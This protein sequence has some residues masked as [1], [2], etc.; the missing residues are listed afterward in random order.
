MLKHWIEGSWWERGSL[1]KVS[2]L[3][4]ST[5]SI[6]T[7]WRK[8]EGL[9][10]LCSLLVTSPWLSREFCTASKSEA[11]LHRLKTP[12]SPWADKS[13]GEA[14]TAAPETTPGRQWTPVC[15][16]GKMAQQV[17][18]AGLLACPGNICGSS[19]AEVVSRKLVTHQYVSHN[20][21]GSAVI[22]TCGTG[23]PPDY[24]GLNCF[25]YCSMV[26]SWITL[27]PQVKKVFPH[28]IIHCVWM[29]ATWEIWLEKGI[30]LK[31]AKLY[32]NYLGAVIHKNNLLLKTPIMGMTLALK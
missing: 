9:P 31:T 23:N 17:P 22:P 13:D 2:K 5:A 12:R 20:W 29:E 14:C 10:P 18:K 16:H 1:G 19:I 15:L 27:P 32:L 3:Q 8:A 4:H 28:L 25:R 6:Y 7:Q 24:P 21:L 26:L 11:W 30:K